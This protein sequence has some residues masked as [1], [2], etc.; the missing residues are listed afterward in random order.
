M[1]RSEKTS[2]PA[3]TGEPDLQNTPTMLGD[4]WDVEYAPTET[5]DKLGTKYAPTKFS[6]KTN[7]APGPMAVPT[8]QNPTTEPP[9][10]IGPLLVRKLNLVGST[11]G[12]GVSRSP[13]RLDE[14]W[15]LYDVIPNAPPPLTADNAVWQSGAVDIL[16]L[17]KARALAN[18]AGTYKYQLTAG[19]D[20]Y[21]KNIVP[22]SM[23]ERF[24]TVGSVAPVLDNL[25]ATAYTPVLVDATGAV[26][27]LDLKYW[28]VDGLNKY[29]EFPY[30]VPKNMKAPFSIS[31]FQ[32]VGPTGGGTVVPPS[33][34]HTWVYTADTATASDVFIPN[35]GA[36]FP[37][38]KV[39]NWMVGEQGAAGSGVVVTSGNGAGTKIIFDVLSKGG[40]FRAGHATGAQWDLGS[41]GTASV[42]LGQ[43]GVASAAFSAV[44]GGD[45]NTAAGTR[46]AVVGG[47]GNITLGIDSFLAGGQNNHIDLVDAGGADNTFIVGGY[48]SLV[49]QAA[50]GGSSADNAG[51]LG[52][53]THLVDSGGG[54]VDNCVVVGGHTNA[55]ASAAASS[56]ANSVILGGNNI[57]ALPGQADTAYCQ[58]LHQKGGLQ[59]PVKALVAGDSPF[60]ATAYH[61]AFDVDTTAGPVT[62][63]L[64]AAP[65]AGQYFSVKRRAGAS[66]VTLD[67]GAKNIDDGVGGAATTLVL[68]F[69]GEYANVV[70]DAASD[71]WALIGT[72]MDPPAVSHPWVYTMDAVVIADTIFVPSAVFPGAGVTRLAFGEKGAG[73]SGTVVDS[74][75]GAGTRLTFDPLSK[76]GALRA[77]RVTGTQWDLASVGASSAALGV[78]NTAAGASSFVAGEGSTANSLSLRAFV[79]GG[80]LHAIT[81]APDGF[82]GGGT[83]S[84]IDANSGSAANCAVVGGSNNTI[85][86]A[87]GLSADNCV[88][89]GGANITALTGQD[90]TAYT[91]IL[92]Q[93]GGHQIPVKSV[94]VAGPT[95]VT[96]DDYVFTVDTA[97]VA[98]TLTLP[99]APVAG[100]KYHF[101]VMPGGGAFPLVI[102]GNGNSLVRYYDGGIAGT[103]S[104]NNAL[105]SVTYV[106]SPL[107][108]WVPLQVKLQDLVPSLNSTFV[109][110]DASK[111]WASVFAVVYNVVDAN[112]ALSNAGGTVPTVTFDTGDAIAYTR[113]TNTFLFTANG[114]AATLTSA[115]L[116][117]NAVLPYTDATYN[118]GSTSFRWKQL[119]VNDASTGGGKNNVII[120]SGSPPTI[121]S[122]DLNVL[123]GNNNIGL[124]IT[125]EGAN[126]FVGNHTGSLIAGGTATNNTSVGC[127]ALFS[128]TGGAWNSALGYSALRNI[129]SGTH[130][131]G[132]GIQAGYNITTGIGNVVSGYGNPASA[133]ATG[134][135]NVLLGY[136]CDAPAAAVYS[137]ALG[138]LAVAQANYH[139]QI[140]QRTNSGSSAYMSFRTQDVISETMIDGNSYLVTNNATGSYVKASAVTHGGSLSITGQTNVNGA[141]VSPIEA[142]A[143]SD[144]GVTL[145]N[146]KRLYEITT[147]T[148]TGAFA[149]N[150][151]A[152]PITGQIIS[153]YNASVYVTTGAFSLAADTGGTYFYST[154]ATWVSV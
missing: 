35:S 101:F 129:N 143:G 147:G 107:G 54:S 104:L 29:V 9:V 91:Q 13:V 18:V 134:S 48:D 6:A 56:A 116:T 71:I 58:I 92:H 122:G 80:T 7:M 96:A 146:N 111:R 149:C 88:V 144:A 63:T 32:Y 53:H 127:S 90:N 106:W 125:T 61:Y 103:V 115:S 67:G 10:F 79:A 41:M 141:Q 59:V 65:V 136:D 44:V 43:D 37:D 112:F 66:A 27:P 12:D 38:G 142:V 64:P 98:V 135:Y 19:N 39:A 153:V 57:T 3:P 76:A 78:N 148:A 126:V 69:A 140:G 77:G 75:E 121:T 109:L 60:A 123:V 105:E 34:T 89:L 31:F 102:D 70:W 93:T 36:L 68:T 119:R 151:P 28:V 33:N 124:G 45:T 11:N 22:A 137:V 108:A 86:S 97:T 46:A 49:V 139:V 118:L 72:N 21:L 95:A 74:V 120:V 73:G 52:G 40:A 17:V 87:V 81:G 150:G 110:G 14:I 152:A 2:A 130:N 25:P 132:T 114:D 84:V 16:R 4:T 42:A 23:G 154:G 138:S 99:A 117:T 20:T 30:G 26:F 62:V 15:D 5:G 1:S 113:A 85:A 24:P 94:T 8:T 100:Q 131:V 55:I 47:V 145:A 83:S 82:V 128:L 133:L 51:V 50:G